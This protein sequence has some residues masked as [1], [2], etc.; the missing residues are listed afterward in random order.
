MILRFMYAL[1]ERSCS[2]KFKMSIPFLNKFIKSSEKSIS[3]LQFL[4]YVRRVDI[5]EA[6]NVMKGGNVN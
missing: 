3:K 6:S 5:C 4:G 1:T 2:I